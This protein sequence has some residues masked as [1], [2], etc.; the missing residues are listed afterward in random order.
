MEIV[1]NVTTTRAIENDL[2]L[3]LQLAPSFQDLEPLDFFGSIVQWYDKLLCTPIR[4]LL[5]SFNPEACLDFLWSGGGGEGG[6]VCVSDSL[7]SL[8]FHLFH[9]V[10]FPPFSLS[11]SLSLSSYLFS[12][13]LA[14]KS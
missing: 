8:P 11:L 2:G 10:T 7:F 4:D 12:V 13:R 3:L 9:Q 1:L 6:A 5:S 14:E